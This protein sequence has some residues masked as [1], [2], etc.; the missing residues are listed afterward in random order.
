MIF[1]FRWIQNPDR[2][3]GPNPRNMINIA[4]PGSPGAAVYED[5]YKDCYKRKM[6]TH[7][8]CYEST[9]P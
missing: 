2:G 7:A 9:N 3:N 4:L 6:A 1:C 8:R 5:Y